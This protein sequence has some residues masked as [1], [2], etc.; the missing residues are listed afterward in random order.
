MIHQSELS[1]APPWIT[2]RRIDI[3]PEM[4]AMLFVVVD[5]EEEFDWTSA[6]S[7]KNTSVRAIQQLPLLQRLLDRYHV[8]PTYV[9]DYPVATSPV[10]SVVIRDLYESG[11]CAVGAH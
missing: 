11:N 3:S 5:T 4:P 6:F 7:R 1:P 9:I 2:A 10:S 8:K